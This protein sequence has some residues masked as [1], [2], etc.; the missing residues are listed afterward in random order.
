MVNTAGVC[1]SDDTWNV[2]DI[3]LN[4]VRLYVPTPAHTPNTLTLLWSLIS[5]GMN[6]KPLGFRQKKRL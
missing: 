3:M 4:W 5:G 1:G 2:G 6:G